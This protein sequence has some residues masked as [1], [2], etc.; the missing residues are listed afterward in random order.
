MAAR[1]DLMTALGIRDTYLFLFDQ[2]LVHTDGAL[3]MNAL[4]R[5]RGMR[6]R[7]GYTLTWLS[8][9]LL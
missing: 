3:W 7:D 2:A 6:V 8:C 1:Y 5:F 9:V 4:R